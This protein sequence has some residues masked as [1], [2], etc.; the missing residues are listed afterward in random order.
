MHILL[1]EEDSVEVEEV[2]EEHGCTQFLEPQMG[3]I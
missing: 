1:P 2:E 3:V